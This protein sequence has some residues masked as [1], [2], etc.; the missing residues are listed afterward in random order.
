MELKT[1]IPCAWHRYMEN[2]HIYME[3][4]AVVFVVKVAETN[5][6]E[7]RFKHQ[8]Y[9]V[10]LVFLCCYLSPQYFHSYSTHCWKGGQ[11]IPPFHITKIAMISCGN[12]F[13][14]LGCFTTAKLHARIFF[15]ISDAMLLVLLSCPI[16][17]T[18]LSP[19]ENVR[20]FLPNINIKEHPSYAPGS[21]KTPVLRMA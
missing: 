12:W 10:S 18:L 3:K 21:C 5:Q 9:T 6:T 19:C 11:I 13:A 7:H 8:K 14:T 2:D 15:Y 20:I 1:F 17:S 16:C 4:T